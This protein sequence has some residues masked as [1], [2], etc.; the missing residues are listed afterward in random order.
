M[1]F[2]WSVNAQEAPLPRSPEHLA[3][4]GRQVWGARP[5]SV[6]RGPA[7][8]LGVAGQCTPTSRHSSRSRRPPAGAVENRS[9]A[10]RGQ[11]DP[12]SAAAA[13]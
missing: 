9:C 13:W 12:R 3:G 6:Q 4:L 11:G 1:L 2:Y 10:P 7:T 8:L 5:S